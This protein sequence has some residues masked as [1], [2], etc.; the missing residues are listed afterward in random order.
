MFR[1]RKETKKGELKGYAQWL[2]DKAGIHTDDALNVSMRARFTPYLNVIIRRHGLLMIVREVAESGHAMM[3]QDR[4]V[5][6]DVE[7]DSFSELLEESW[8]IIN[9]HLEDSLIQSMK[10]AYITGPFS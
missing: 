9:R 4:E 1:F 10:E 2:T 5:L 7:F 3:T 6:L 8:T